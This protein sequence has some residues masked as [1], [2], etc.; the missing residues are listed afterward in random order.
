MI[1]KLMV[2]KSICIL[3]TLLLPMAL[4][5]GQQATDFDSVTRDQIE[6]TLKAAKTMCVISLSYQLVGIGFFIGATSDVTEWIGPG[7]VGVLL[8]TGG[9][10]MEL[11]NA[12]LTRRAYVQIGSFS[13]PPEVSLLKE[14]MLKNMKTART[15][16]VMQNFVPFIALATGGIAYLISGGESKVF[17]ITA[18]TLWTGGLLSMALPEIMLIEKTR[19]D[20]DKY[21]QRLTLGPSNY[22]MGMVFHF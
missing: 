15:L 4:T 20:L 3:F 11:N 9:A 22:G 16:A 6:R 2:M 12:Q 19:H 17:S 1:S 5:R 21:Q 8:A 7:S 14:E 18:I 10:G 13:S